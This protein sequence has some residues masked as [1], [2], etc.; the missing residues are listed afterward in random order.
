MRFKQLVAEIG[1]DNYDEFIRREIS[2]LNFF[3]D[4]KMSCLMVFPILESLAEEFNDKIFFGKINIEESQEIA[5]LHD[6]KK[7]PCVLVFKNGEQIDR[8]EN[9]DSEEIL[10]DRI[11]CLI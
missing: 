1:M 10:R 4:W 8:I 5:Q 11:C 3:S 2:V 7:V 9:C 6:V